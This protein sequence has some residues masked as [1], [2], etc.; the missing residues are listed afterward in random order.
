MIYVETAAAAE[1]FCVSLSALKEATRRNSAKYPF[2]RIEGAGARSRGGVKL[3]FAVEIAGVDAAI[4]IGKI[5]KDIDVYLPDNAQECGYRAVKFSEFSRADEAFRVNLGNNASVRPLKFVKGEEYGSGR[6]NNAAIANDLVSRR[7]RSRGASGARDTGASQ[8]NEEVNAVYTVSNL[9]ELKS[10]SIG[11]DHSGD[12]A[13]GRKNKNLDAVAN[14]DLRHHS[15]SEDNRAALAR[16]ALDKSEVLG[17]AKL[18]GVKA[19]AQAFGAKEKSIYRW[20]K[21]FAQK[22]GEALED[23]RGG[24]SKANVKMIKDAILSIGT[25]QKT[26][27]WME[28]CRRYALSKGLY[29]DMFA[30]LSA[31]ISRSTFLRHA[32][33]IASKD[34]EVRTFLRAGRDGLNTNISIKRNYLKVNEEWQVDATPYDFM[35]LDENGEPVRYTAVGIIDVGGEMRVYD[36][37][38]SPNGYANVRL[39]KKALKEMGRPG[40]IKGDHGKDYVGKHFQ[41]VLKRLGVQYAKAPK[42][43]GKAKGKIERCHKEIQDFFEGLPGFLGHNVGDRALREK[44][45]EDKAA[46]L[47]GAKTN[48]KNLMTRDQMQT[49]MDRWCESFKGSEEIE[50]FSFDERVFGRSEE[51]ILQAEGFSINGLKFT[52]LEVF[53]HAKIGDRLETIENIDDASV[54]HVY[55]DG[56]YICDVV[57]QDVAKMSAEEVKAAQKEYEKRVIRPTKAYIRSLQNEKDGYYKADAERRLKEARKGKAEVIKKDEAKVVSKIE[58]EASVGNNV[59]YLPDPADAIKSLEG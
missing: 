17:Y 47:S 53:R 2:I 13:A 19:A 15:S 52:D 32:S 37:C 55:K 31:D 56:E 39:L 26:S 51:K 6:D 11:L 21:E 49:M 58:Q 33:N 30:P 44:Q 42:F 8:G 24:T 27:W 50:E 54:Y 16:K 34:Y 10:G 12:L 7:D 5:D 46:M 29:F 35:C 36:L 28:Y 4:N 18:Y 1:I 48:I 41:G 57:N 43:T 59:I 38:D 25:A 14:R 22:G 9:E 20:Q 3:L 40:Y 23:K 45:A